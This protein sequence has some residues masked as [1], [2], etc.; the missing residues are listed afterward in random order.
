MN[1][2]PMASVLPV[3]LPGSPAE[4]LSALFDAHHDRLYRLARRLAPNVDDALDLV[5]ETFLKAARAPCRSHADRRARKRGSSACSSTSV[6]ISG[7]GR[8]FASATQEK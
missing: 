4:R 2:L 3:A 1:G 5:Q 7:A 8:R 6:A